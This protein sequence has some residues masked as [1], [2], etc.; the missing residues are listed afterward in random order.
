MRQL[1]RSNVTARPNSLLDRSGGSIQARGK[2]E[3]AKATI[4]RR[5]VN[6]DVG[7]LN[8][9]N[10]MLLSEGQYILRAVFCSGR[11]ATYVDHL[12]GR[13]IEKNHMNLEVGR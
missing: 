6:S 7:Q 1:S 5:P 3:R 12:V 2:G 11:V 8:V 13:K 4:S 10:P 9:S